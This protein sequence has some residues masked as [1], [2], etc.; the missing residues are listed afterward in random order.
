MDIPEIDLMALYSGIQQEML[1]ML[2]AGNMA[3]SHPGIKGH[4]T[5]ANWIQWFRV[6]LPARYSHLVFEQRK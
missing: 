2:I 5:E 4:T 6:Y 3:F 1:N